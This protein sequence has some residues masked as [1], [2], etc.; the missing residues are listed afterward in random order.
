MPF[1]FG[2]GFPANR[3][4]VKHGRLWRFDAQDV[5]LF[6]PRP[7][8]TTFVAGEIPGIIKLLT[9]LKFNIAPENRPS[10]KESSTP[11]IY[12]Q[13]RTVSFREC[14]YFWGGSQIMQM[15]DDFEGCPL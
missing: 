2:S 11:T 10:Q 12:F 14:T 13:G 5:F 8:G 4:Q 7:D 3:S 9:H 1:S 6:S 15:Y